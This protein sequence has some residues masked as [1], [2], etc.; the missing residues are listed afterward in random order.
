[1]LVATRSLSE[2]NERQN[3]CRNTEGLASTS[4]LRESLNAHF[5][6][7]PVAAPAQGKNVRRIKAVHADHLINSPAALQDLRIPAPGSKG[8]HWIVP[9][10]TSA[11]SN[12]TRMRVGSAGQGKAR[13]TPVTM[14]FS[15]NQI[16]SRI[17]AAHRTL[18]LNW[19]RWCATSRDSLPMK[20][21]GGD[22]RKLIEWFDVRMMVGALKFS[23]APARGIGLVPTNNI[24]LQL[25]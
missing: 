13:S 16:D 8:R 21:V 24:S 14:G 6:G 11:P 15:R 3:T 23:C 5:K 12:L 17:Y 4:G 1:V 9:P 20:L 25:R 10:S 19:Q 7:P 22:A 2:D 18:R